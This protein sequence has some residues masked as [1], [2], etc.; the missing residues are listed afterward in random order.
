M[1]GYDMVTRL[2][3]NDSYSFNFKSYP[4]YVYLRLNLDC[5]SSKAVNNL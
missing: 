5:M 2:D 1:N 4:S 3:Y